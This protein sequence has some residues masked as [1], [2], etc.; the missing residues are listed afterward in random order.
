MLTSESAEQ[1]KPPHNDK[2][3][4]LPTLKKK[5]NYSVFFAS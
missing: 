5:D 4:V 2:E 1:T 3:S